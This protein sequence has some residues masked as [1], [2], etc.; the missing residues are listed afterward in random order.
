M[1]VEVNGVHQEVS[2]DT[3]LSDLLCQLNIQQGR[4]AVELN[5]TVIN[6]NQ[7]DRS[8][9]EGDKIEIINFVGGGEATAPCEQ[10]SDRCRGGQ[11]K[12]D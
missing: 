8:L 7:F 9:K 10:T 12:V 1:Q 3:T 11:V 4:V 5:L 2:I 6:R